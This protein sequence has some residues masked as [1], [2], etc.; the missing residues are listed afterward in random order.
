LLISNGDYNPAKIDPASAA[1]VEVVTPDGQDVK[2]TFDL[3]E[4]R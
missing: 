3:A 2:T 4:L 1:T